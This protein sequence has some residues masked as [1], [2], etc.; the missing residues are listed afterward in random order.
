MKEFTIKELLVPLSEYATVPMGA[1]LYD[2][3]LALEKTQDEFDHANYRHRAVLVLDDGG[4]VAGKLSQLDVLYALEPEMDESREAGLLSCFG[5]SP[6]LIWTVQKEKR[7]EGSLSERHFGEAAC[8]K[9][10]NFMNAPAE[11]EFVDQ[12]APLK[13]AIHQLIVGHH[14]SLLV[15]DQKRIVG[16]LRL[17]DV[18][19]AIFHMMKHTPPGNDEERP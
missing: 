15:T 3:I 11:G 7:P 9:V 5:F 18:F 1:T 19:A 8:L 16:I 12:E 6:S 10:E 2:A 4:Q 14:F 13:Q 17:T